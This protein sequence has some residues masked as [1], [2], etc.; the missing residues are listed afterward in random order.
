[1][2]NP[3][4]AIDLITFFHPTFWGL[5]TEAEV[6]RYG[7]SEP[8]AFWDRILDTLEESGVS[9]IE[10]TFSP[11]SWED[12]LAAY[13]SVESFKVELD[14]RGLRLATGF[15]ADV[16]IQGDLQDP[17]K[18]DHYIERGTAYA[19]YLQAF[20]VTA[21]VMGLPMRTTWSDLPPRFVGFDEAKI[22]ADFSNRLGAATLRHGVMLAL[23]TEAHSIFSLARDV[24]LLMMLT[25]PVFVGFCPDTAQIL[26]GGSDPVEVVGRHK[27][28]LVAAHWKDA[29]GPAPV[30]TLIDETI[31][32]QHREFFCALG[33]GKIDWTAWR[34]LLH[35]AGYKGWT[36]L[37]IDA[38]PD[39]VAEVTKSM[40]F[41]KTHI[42]NKAE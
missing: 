30:R 27:E 20:G 10:L 3:E 29:I 40:T 37:E 36:I 14:K 16:A 5:E 21:M 8:R 24:D 25:D 22:A 12:T 7:Q 39:P 4:C 1:M 28:R 35:M 18:R 33:E 2:N 11:F 15:F 19:A 31:H 32:F 34:D 9:G 38:V 26:L 42:F 6:V 17:A 41:L 13:G 23:H